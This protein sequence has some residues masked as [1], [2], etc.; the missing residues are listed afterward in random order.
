[1]A[2]DERQF[3]RFMSGHDVRA[4]RGALGEL[5]GLGRPLTMRQM[6]RALRLT[7]R[8]I[9]ASV[10]DYERGRTEV[11][12]PLSALIELYLR[13]AAPVD[14]LEAVLQPGEDE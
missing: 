10:R 9:G 8:N 13:G 1:M 7:G 5:W 2:E 6:G 14:G 12:G 4:A 11:S 3:N